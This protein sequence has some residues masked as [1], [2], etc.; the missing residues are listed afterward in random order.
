[1]R[2]KPLPA[3]TYA[4]M[5]EATATRLRGV[6]RP[7]TAKRMRENNP[8]ADPVNVLKVTQKMKG[9]T[10]LARGGNGQLTKP[11]TLLADLLGFPTEYAISTVGAVGA[12]LPPCYKVDLAVPHLKL[13]IEVDGRTHTSKKWKFLDHRKTE[14]LASLGWSVLRFWNQ[15]VLQNTSEV[16]AKIQECMTLRSKEITTTLPTVSSSPTATA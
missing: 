3:E 8:M 1:M 15:E 12:S 14:V 2:V 6:A 16:V 5:G 10:F 7:D 13:A 4:R 9:R 11:Q